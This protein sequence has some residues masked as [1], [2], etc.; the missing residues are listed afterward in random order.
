MLGGAV[1]D[2]NNL[3]Y[4]YPNISESYHLGLFEILT[5]FLMDAPAVDTIKKQEIISHWVSLR[6]NILSYQ[7]TSGFRFLGWRSNVLNPKSLINTESI[8]IN[9]L[10]FGACAIHV[11]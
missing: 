10:G 7:E 3:R 5:W 4:V 2:Q 8:A 1:Y 6:S 11:F 9:V